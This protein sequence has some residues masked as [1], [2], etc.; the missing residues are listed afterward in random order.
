MSQNP[1]KPFVDYLLSN[2]TQVKTVVKIADELD[3][4]PMISFKFILLLRDHNIRILEQIKQT[5]I[6]GDQIE[7]DVCRHYQVYIDTRSGV[8]KHAVREM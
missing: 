6:E 3:V 7:D 4:C 8:M 2:T 1:K 5:L